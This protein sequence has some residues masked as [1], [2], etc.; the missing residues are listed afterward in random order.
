[1]VQ[2]RVGKHEIVNRFWIRRQGL[3]VAVLE[4]LRT[5]KDSAIHQQPL[6]R[7]FHK[8]SRARNA[9]CRA[10]KS[11]F[12]HRPA[13]LQNSWHW[14]TLALSASTRENGTSHSTRPASK[15]THT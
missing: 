9:T 14:H 1:M 5:L 10:K 8:I 3:V 13:I 12:C 4:L 6:A 11:E 2:V 7:R 15:S